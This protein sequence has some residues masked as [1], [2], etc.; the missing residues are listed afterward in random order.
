MARRRR[1]HGYRGPKTIVDLG[2]SGKTT[3]SSVY[4]ENFTPPSLPGPRN[5]VVIMASMESGDTRTIN[6]KTFG[7]N[8]HA[9]QNNYG[10]VRDPSITILY[11]DWSSGAN[12][13]SLGINTACDNCRHQGI[14]VDGLIDR[15]SMDSTRLQGTDNAGM[16][17]F[18]EASTWG[19]S[20]RDARALLFGIG[21]HT[22]DTAWNASGIGGIGDGNETYSWD[23]LWEWSLETSRTTQ[24]G[25]GVFWN[26]ADNTSVEGHFDNNDNT[27][28][29]LRG[30]GF[31]IL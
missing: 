9:Q 27:P 6:S 23:H 15:T 14:F 20:H 11:N 1:N 22:Q 17:D 5:A 31:T 16:V 8:A 10:G 18:P 12:S 13:S 24:H 19:K 25:I 28:Q 29:R 26:K 7:G 2:N 4:S 21:L 3:N 30:N